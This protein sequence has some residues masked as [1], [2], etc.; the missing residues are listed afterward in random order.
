MASDVPSVSDHELVA[1]TDDEND[2]ALG[3]DVSTYT[4]TLRSSL[5]QN[6]S[7]NGREYHKYRQG[8]YILPNDEVELDRLDLQHH[9]WRITLDGRQHVAPIS[10]NPE[11]VLDVGT[12]T[13]LWAIEFADEHPSAHVLGVDLSPTQPGFVPPNCKFEIDDCEEPWAYTHKFDFI[14]ARM[15]IA[16]FTDWPNFFRQ[17]YDSLKPGGWMEMQDTCFPMLSDDGTLAP[18]GALHTWNQLMVRGGEIA[19]R[20]ITVSARYKQWMLETGFVDV[21][22]VKHKWPQNTWPKDP[23]Y[24]ELGSWTLTNILEGLQGF[25]LAPMTRCLGMSRE[26]VE[27]LLVDV[28][29]DMKNR[30]IHSYWPM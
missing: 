17:A 13:G 18:G 27:L 9:I 12:G 22:E 14:H 20:E 5:L 30:A 7:E 28:R 29:K 10:E 2:S 21:V 3:D 6:V 23:R 8:Q 11:Y 4:E 19:G 16:A 1:D 24:K 26:E 25:S 15:M